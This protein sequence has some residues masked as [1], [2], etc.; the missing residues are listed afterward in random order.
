MYIYYSGNFLRG[1]VFA[2]VVDNQ[3]TVKLKHKNKHGCTVCNGLP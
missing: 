2:I 3:V 1:P